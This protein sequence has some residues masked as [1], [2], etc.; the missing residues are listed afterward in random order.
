MAGWPSGCAAVSDRRHE[1]GGGRSTTSQ[2]LGPPDQRQHCG[3]PGGPRLPGAQGQLWQCT[4]V[5]CPT[6]PT[7]WGGGHQPR[8]LPDAHR[9]MSGF[10]RDATSLGLRL[11]GSQGPM[12]HNLC[13]FR[14]GEKGSQSWPQCLPQTQRRP[15]RAGPEG[16]RSPGTSSTHH[17]GP[18]PATGA[19]PRRQRLG[20]GR[21]SVPNLAQR[22]A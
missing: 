4:G 2:L 7:Y 5:L 11:R 20:L 12:S 9:A 18:I 10:P 16:V 22:S 13:A 8:P 14:L 19:A 1:A 17:I 6:A 21:Q 3:R 15:G